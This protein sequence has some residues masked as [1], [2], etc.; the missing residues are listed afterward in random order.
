VVV[1]DHSQ[2]LGEDTAWDGKRQGRA[3]E[4]Q[5][6]NQLVTWSRFSQYDTHD[7]HDKGYDFFRLYLTAHS[8]A[9]RG[10]GLDG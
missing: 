8:L 4:E 9:G 5:G 10:V 1:P 3:R 2:G 7:I 6:W